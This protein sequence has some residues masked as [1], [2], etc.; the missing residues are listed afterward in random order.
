VSRTG[1][2]RADSTEAFEGVGAPTCC[3]SFDDDCL[4]FTRREASYCWNNPDGVYDTTRPGYC[5]LLHGPFASDA[6]PTP[7][8]ETET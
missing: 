7:P 4:Y 5:P 8:A 1:E 2:G 3:P 6:A